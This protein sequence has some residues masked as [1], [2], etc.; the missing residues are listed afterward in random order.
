MNALTTMADAIDRARAMAVRKG[1]SVYVLR[2]ADGFRAAV[3]CDDE[4]LAVVAVVAPDGSVH[5][6]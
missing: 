6:F 3:F 5:G 4:P 2:A 1:M